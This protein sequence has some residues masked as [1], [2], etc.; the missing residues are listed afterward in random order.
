M[1]SSFFSAL[2]CLTLVAC[3]PPTSPSATLPASTLAEATAVIQ[4][5]EVGAEPHGIAAAAGFVYNSNSGEQT[6]TVIDTQTD[7]LLQSLNLDPANPAYIKALP[8]QSH[9]LLLDSTGQLHVLEASTQQTLQKL[10][11]ASG[12]DQ[13]VLG[14]NPQDVYVSLTGEAAVMHLH[15][16]AGFAAEPDIRRLPAG[17]P[18]ADGGGHRSLAV[19]QHWLATVNPGDNDV[20][21]IHLPTGEMQRI[22]A[23]NDPGTLQ[24]GSWEGQ[25]RVLIIGNRASHTLTL[26]HLETGVSQ[27]LENVGLS[28]TEILVIPELERAFVSMAGS[29][30]VAVVN[31]RQQ[32]LLG[33]VAVGSRPVHLYRAPA[34]E[35]LHIQHAGHD[36]SAPEVWVSNDGGASV[37]IL[38]A[39]TLAVLATVPVGKGHHK[40]AF[41]H[42]KA[43]VSNISEASISVIDRLRLPYMQED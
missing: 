22:Q 4:T 32:R 33:K 34:I 21:L 30:E 5:L 36:H 2:V 17:T 24:F 43:Y 9:V 18:Q 12:T 13:I 40:M 26:Y 29:N 25:E 37:S 1:R 16:G 28:P 7:R 20:S 35:P 19:G 10:S 3:Q 15:F 27:T 14:A 38:D 6:V 31:Y 23:G 11:L 39:Q 8:D 41:T 42:N